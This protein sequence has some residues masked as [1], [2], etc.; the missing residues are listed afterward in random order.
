MQDVSPRGARR[1]AMTTETHFDGSAR[2]PYSASV[3]LQPCEALPEQR[4]W[5]SRD[6]A[7]IVYSCWRRDRRRASDFD[8]YKTRSLFTLGGGWRPR[9]I[10]LPRMPNKVAETPRDHMAGP[11]CGDE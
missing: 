3:F 8:A 4:G 1:P 11:W 9:R 10:S 2:S 5:V 7:A 6:A